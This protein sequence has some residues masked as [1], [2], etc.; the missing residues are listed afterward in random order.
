MRIYDVATLA[1]T[2]FNVQVIN[3]LQQF[4]RGK[5]EFQCI[6]APKDRDLFLCFY[7]CRATYTDKD[8]RTFHAQSGDVVYTPRGSEYRVVLHDFESE[9]SQ[10]VGIN[11][12][13]FDKNGEEIAISDTIKIFHPTSGRALQTAQKLIGGDSTL[14]YLK[15]RAYLLDIIC[16]IDDSPSKVDDIIAPGYTYL[17][18]HFDE[19][20]QISFLAKMCNVSEVYFRRI[21]RQC[22]GESPIKYRNRLRLEKAKEYLEYGDV[23]ILEIS[24][25]LGYSSPSHFTK[26]FSLQYGIKPLS[27]RQRYRNSK[28]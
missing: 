16:S 1:E 18:E 28:K 11:F 7:G 25:L 23:S 15:K 17:T 3:V 22:L 5:K 10:T 12:L 24:E 26:E 2:D 27:Y 21:F 14:S 6:G 9:E 20:V 19:A 8:Q 4:W 13:L